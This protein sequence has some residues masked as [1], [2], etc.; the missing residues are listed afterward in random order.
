MNGVTKSRF[1]VC[2]WGGGGGGEGGRVLG[3]REKDYFRSH[4]PENSLRTESPLSP[5]AVTHWPL[6]LPH[7]SPVSRPPKAWCSPASLVLLA[8]R[9]LR[10]PLA[11]PG[12]GL[13]LAP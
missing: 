10:L 5:G 3:S 4:A 12:G 11:G 7:F 8:G 6:G 9:F 1:E 13:A 2:A